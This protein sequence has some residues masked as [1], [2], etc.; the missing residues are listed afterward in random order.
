LQERIQSDENTSWQIK[1]LE[2][3]LCYALQKRI[4]RAVG[5]EMKNLRCAAERIQRI[6][7]HKIKGLLHR[8]YSRKSSLKNELE[9]F[10][11]T[12]ISLLVFGL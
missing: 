2:R 9:A 3:D 11:F 1:L 7:A 8:Q 10:L 12:G 4:Q 6:V 5:L